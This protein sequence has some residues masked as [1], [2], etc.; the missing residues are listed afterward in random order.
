[1]PDWIEISSTFEPFP[2][3]VV[4]AGLDLGESAAITLCLRKN[5][6]A[7]LID[8]SPGRI[9]AAKPGIRT[10]G[11]L[12]ILI[13][14]QKRKLIPTVKFLLEKLEGGRVLDRAGFAQSC[15]ATGWRIISCS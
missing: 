13:E 4:Q 5:A 11:I 8:E 12:G 3:E 6:D 1:M 15:F 9:I 14:S 2:P 7:L 10:I